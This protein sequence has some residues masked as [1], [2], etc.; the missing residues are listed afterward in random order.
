MPPEQF[1][2]RKLAGLW[3]KPRTQW[4]VESGMNFSLVIFPSFITNNGLWL[5][6]EFWVGDVELKLQN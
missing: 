4:L 3:Q 5:A 2:V 6:E 1:L